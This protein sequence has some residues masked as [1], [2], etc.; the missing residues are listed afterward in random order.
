MTLSFL[1]G[2]L[3]LMLF[4]FPVGTYTVAALVIFIPALAIGWF[5]VR[6]RVNELALVNPGSHVLPLLSSPVKNDP[7][8]S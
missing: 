3:V 5:A 8:E 1:G 7:K 4:D 2:V 6:K